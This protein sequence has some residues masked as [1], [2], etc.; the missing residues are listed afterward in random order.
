MTDINRRRAR[1][2]VHDRGMTRRAPSSD[3]SAEDS[4]DH[5]RDHPT[6]PEREISMVIRGAPDKSSIGSP[7]DQSAG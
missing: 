4:D 6:T 5:H 7:G 3:A 1:D 2:P